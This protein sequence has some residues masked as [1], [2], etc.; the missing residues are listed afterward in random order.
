MTG[1]AQPAPLLFSTAFGLLMAVASAIHAGRIGSLAALLAALAVLVGL[2]FP[3]AATLAVLMAV[4]AVASSNAYPLY[5]ALAGLSAAAY[6]VIRHA[7]GPSAG[8]VTT[9]RPTVLAMV[10]FTLVGVAATIVPGTFPWLPLAAP[11]AVVVIFVLTALPLVAG[12]V[13]GARGRG[14]R[15][16]N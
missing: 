10:G 4:V 6:L 9:T 7:A 5:A 16:T 13:E 11:A 12:R 8:V 2:R 3:A 14:G 1:S 15:R